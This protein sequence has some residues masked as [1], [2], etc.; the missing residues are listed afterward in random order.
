MKKIILSIY[1]LAIAAIVV[2]QPVPGKPQEKCIAIMNAT[3]HLGNGKVIENSIVLFEKGKIVAVL[4]ATTSRVDISNC[5]V[6]RA[7]G[8]HVYPGIIAPNTNLGLV[9]I[10]SVRATRDFAETGDANPN[11][12]SI[13]SYNTDSKIIPTVRSNG[14]LLAQTTPQGAGI[15]GMSSV[16]QLDAW[17]WEDAAVSTDVG[18][19][20][21]WPSM[22]IAGGPFAATAEMQKERY[23]NFMNN[24]KSFFADAKAYS[25]NPNP[26][27]WNAKL[28]AMK[29]LF[30]GTR[31]L[32]I[33]V[34][35]AKDIIAAVNF[36]LDHGVK[37]VI[38]GGLDAHY[39]AGFLK[40]KNV[41]VILSDTH[42][43]P[44]RRDEDT[45]LPYK[46]AKILQDAGVLFALSTDGYWQIRN[47][48]FMAGTAAGFG[49]TKE[50][51][52][53]AITLNSAKILGID[54]M[55]G[56]LEQGKDAT[57][58]ISEGDALDM[59]GNKVT[60]AFINGRK[61]VLSDKHKDLN[62]RFS[63]K[64]GIE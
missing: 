12:R 62:K 3:A 21:N 52:L 7:E 2:A 38:V 32:Y 5:E 31:K 50:Q 37:P 59:K 36:A 49:L 8:K 24:I 20:I 6:I 61:V 13:I 23:T 15:T 16:V 11:V 35:F 42:S 55:L 47:L 25:E 51:A 40:E 34:N 53:T 9:E 56:S 43:L 17:N 18:I 60:H 1:L 54:K 57:L 10:S 63:D 14:I 45:D 33:N 26:G 41:P 29:P 39:V 19:H 28:A 22:N 48:P 4:D 64:Y 44:A 27:A 58:F 30:N 46:S